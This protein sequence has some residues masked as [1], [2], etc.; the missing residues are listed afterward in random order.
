[1]KKLLL[2][3]C[4]VI[5]ALSLVA[6]SDVFVC[7]HDYADEY[8][9]HERTCIYEDCDH[10]EAATTEHNFG[11]WITIRE[12]SCEGAGTAKRECE[13]GYI[14]TMAIPE[15]GHSYADEYTCHDRACTVED[16]D[17]VSSAST[18]HNFVSEEVI[19]EATCAKSGYTKYT[20]ECG[21]K[22]TREITVAHSFNDE[23]NCEKC[24]KN[25]RE[26]LFTVL[27]E[28]NDSI[29]SKP[30]AG[31]YFFNTNGEGESANE[32]MYVR[33]NGS[34]LTALVELGYEE[35]TLT[36]KNPAPGFADSSNKCKS[37]F[38]A[39]D[40]TSNLWDASTAMVYLDFETFWNGGKS[41]T[42]TLS[43]VAYAGH[44]IY[45]YADY[46]KSYP[47]EV[48]IDE[49][50]NPEDVTNYVVPADNGSV[51]YIEGKG[52]H[53]YT[54]DEVSG[55]YLTIPAKV[56]QHEIKKGNNVLTL[57]YANSFGLD[58]ECAGNPVNT[59][60]AVLPKLASTGG[61]DWTGTKY[62]NWI[63]QFSTADANGYFTARIELDNAA[64]NYNLPITLYFTTTDVLGAATP[65]NYIASIEFSAHTHEYEYALSEA[66][67][68]ITNGTAIGTCSCGGTT[69][70]ELV[71]LVKASNGNVEYVEG[72]GWHVYCTKA[73]GYYFS[74]PAQTVKA[75]VEAGYEK[76]YISFAN[77]FN[78]E[79]VTCAGNPVNVQTAI[80][81]KSVETGSNDWYYLNKFVSQY[82]NKDEAGNYVAIIDLTDTR[83]D[84]T[85]A[86]NIYASYTDVANAAT[87]HTYIAG[88]NFVKHVHEY[89]WSPATDAT[90]AAPWT[91]KGVCECGH[92]TAR[93]E[94][95]ITAG[96]NATVEYVDGKG[97]HVAANDSS[98]GYYFDVPSK[99]ILEYMEKGYT[100]LKISFTNSFGLDLSYAGAAVNCRVAILPK[101]TN[102][103]N[104]WEFLQNYI[105][106]LSHDAETGDYF[107]VLDLTDNNYA[108]AS[109]GLSVYVANIDVNNN[110]V[111]HCYVT[112]V[113]FDGYVAPEEE[114]IPV[115]FSNLTA[116]TTVEYQKVS[117]TYVVTST[118]SS[119]YVQLTAET[120]NQLLADGYYK[121][122]LTIINTATGANDADN[123]MK[124]CYIAPDSGDNLWS[125]DKCIAFYGWKE[126]A[127]AGRKFDVEID[128]ATYAN[129]PIYIFA[130]YCDSY[131]LNIVVEFYNV[132]DLALLEAHD[133]NSTVTYNSITGNYE[134][135]STVSNT[136]SRI[137]PATIKT[138]INCGYEILKVTITNGA[139]RVNASDNHKQVMFGVDGTIWDKN[140]AMAYYLWNEFWDAGGTCSVTI[141]LD[142]Y[143]DLEKNIILYTSNGDKFP[144][145]VSFELTKVADLTLLEAGDANSTVTYNSVTGNYEVSSSVSNTYAKIT[146]D[147]VKTLIKFGYSTL[148]VTFTNGAPRVNAS[149]NHK[150]V[151]FGVDGTI[152]DKN[153]AMAYYLWN[154]FWDAG[155]T[156]TVTINLADYADLEKN[157]ILFTSNG[158][159]Y[160]LLA[161]FALA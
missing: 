90:A 136:Y 43:T 68:A 1:M 55:Y 91:E 117:K 97:W 146:A 13:C 103:G 127:D 161:T 24:S 147:T 33:I 99:L 67:T 105:S 142:D 63:S 149:D 86:I 114:N 83:Y 141:Y 101:K 49:F 92:T 131:A 18:A 58:V 65:H 62:N 85:S 75:Y 102:G 143:A 135:T 121:L 46:C 20:C 138:L 51:E 156:C 28:T 118:E 48:S 98:K 50:F 77:T 122:K 3:V 22:E 71:K 8:T 129:R 41:Y 94:A 109:Y 32:A 116:S 110:V 158:D 144:L 95:R 26:V 157:I 23:G 93:A 9:C 152:W 36:F 35:I 64:Y 4:S 6:C 139:P 47:L 140:T 16:C 56:V 10:V 132:K 145:L 125:A 30:A 59:R 76:L 25:Y 160:P 133:A 39:A 27:D 74:I 5:F 11:E 82:G 34:I 100:E 79:G 38:V 19:T 128:L 12:A 2:I 120:I 53:V 81:P 57:K 40:N 54:T 69:T 42:Y 78:L 130:N 112:G 126:F 21:Y 52:W 88:I 108:Y 151:M 119:A 29:T 111:G 70:T 153:T 61:N 37:V 154:E 87:G 137:T 134:A 155:G 113:V 84:F 80:L 104:D 150:Q 106:Q 89:T 96:E 45:I 72:K 17:Y 148:T 115:I 123:K 66:G 15:T 107:V 73:E 44:D 60:H 159:K 124:S 31:S 14:E 7:G